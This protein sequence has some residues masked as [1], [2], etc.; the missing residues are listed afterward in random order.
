MQL[1][2]RPVGDFV[3]LWYYFWMLLSTERCHMLFWDWLRKHCLSQEQGERQAQ[4]AGFRGA[5]DNSDL[6]S[7]DWVCKDES[8]LW[9]AAMCWP[10]IKS[11]PTFLQRPEP[12][13]PDPVRPTM[14]IFSLGLMV[15]DTFLRT[16]GRFS[17]YLI[18]AFSKVISPS[19]GQSWGGALFLI[20]AGASKERVW[21][22][23]ECFRCLWCSK[24]Y[25]RGQA[26]QARQLPP[27]ARAC[28]K[29]EYFDSKCSHPTNSDRD[30][31]HDHYLGLQLPDCTTLPWPEERPSGGNEAFLS[32]NRFHWNSLKIFHLK[33]NYTTGLN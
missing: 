14:P 25:R 2:G 3:Y 19:W 12:S 23:S 18:S 32:L 8:D 6:C 1:L 27:L 5:W 13:L 33:Q 4:R 10:K 31:A 24:V 7:G 21:G 9:Q 20:L 29:K 28:Y 30:T 17:R 15:K 26:G 22:E 16:R 11:L